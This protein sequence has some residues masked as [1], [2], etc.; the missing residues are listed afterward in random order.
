MSGQLSGASGE[1]S[2]DTEDPIVEAAEDEFSLV[3]VRR[4]NMDSVARHAGVSRATLYRRFPTKSSLIEAVGTRTAR[5]AGKRM[6]RMVEG[7]PPKEALVIAVAEYARMLRTLPLWQEL[8]HHAVLR[9]NEGDRTVG[10]LFT[11]EK[12]ITESIDSIM[13]LLRSAGATMP[14]EELRIVAEITLRMATSFVVS[15]S[16]VVDVDDDKSLRNFVR[17]YLSPMVY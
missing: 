5:W 10:G 17:T 11:S 2:G 13:L 7:Q 8:V 12:F 16:A 6:A 15:P 3:G 9:Y 4:A 14:D 1:F